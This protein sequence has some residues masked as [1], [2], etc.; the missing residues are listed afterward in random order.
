M[1][2]IRN[3]KDPLGVIILLPVKTRLFSDMQYVCVC[4]CVCVCRES[5][6]QE[7]MAGVRSTARPEMEARRRVQAG[8]AEGP[9]IL[10]PGLELGQVER[11]HQGSANCTA[12]LSPSSESAS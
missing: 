1:T 7:V 9:L 3:E 8:E 11:H 6:K 12:V 2:E 10:Q 4:V 5:C